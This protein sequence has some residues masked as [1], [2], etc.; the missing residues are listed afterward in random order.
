MVG[1]PSRQFSPVESNERRAGDAREGAG[2]GGGRVA[3][4]HHGTL[5]PRPVRDSAGSTL[6]T[7][8]RRATFKMHTPPTSSASSRRLRADKVPI[9]P[10]A[11]IVS[12]GAPICFLP[13]HT[14]QLHL[15][16]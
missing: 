16:S 11:A 12:A 1:I 2:A 3:S 14:M 8:N 9:F 10:R 13:L 4:G 6:R 15:C 5:P 7:Q